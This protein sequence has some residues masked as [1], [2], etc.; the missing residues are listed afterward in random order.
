MLLFSFSESKFNFF[1][2]IAARETLDFIYCFCDIYRFSKMEDKMD[3]PLSQNDSLY[4]ILLMSS[5]IDTSTSES[6]QPEIP[7]L[8]RRIDHEFPVD[9]DEDNEFESA[10]QR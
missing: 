4:D 1:F 6:I 7:A 8:L 10:K 9:E 2:E 3:Y 5:L